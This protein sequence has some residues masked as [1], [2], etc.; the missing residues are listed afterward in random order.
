M[1]DDRYTIAASVALYLLAAKGIVNIKPR[2]VQLAVV[3]VIIV[4]SAVSAQAYV[5]NQSTEN[6]AKEAWIQSKETFSVINQQGR[7][8]DLVILSPGLWTVNRYYNNVKGINAPLLRA[9]STIQDNSNLQ[10]NASKYDRVWFVAYSY[11]APPTT[12]EKMVLSAFNETHAITYVK[13]SQGYRVYL[14]EKLA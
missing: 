8:G 12:L 10:A 14:F 13:N 9:G 2:T 7:S 5:N 6:W 11:D 1:F 3:T 4:L